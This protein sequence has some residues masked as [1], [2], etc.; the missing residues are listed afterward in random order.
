MP[1]HPPRGAPVPHLPS[2][3]E[4]LRSALALVLFLLPALAPAARGQVEITP[5]VGSFYALTSVS[6]QQDV[7]LPDFAGAPPGSIV[8]EQEDAPVLGARV[9]FPLTGTI[10][11]EGELGFAFSYG[12]LAELPRANPDA[13]LTARS[14]GH[15]YLASARAVFRP[16]RQN[17]YGLAGLGLVG[18]GGKFW[19]TADPGTKVAG[20]LGFGVRAAVSPAFSLNFSAEAYLYSFGYE[21]QGVSTGSKFQQDI[22]VA[23]GIPIGAR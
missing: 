10:R 14:K 19:E 1:G 6:E 13:G 2:S 8:R 12:R 15:M 5:F 20:V 23:I 4:S 7:P 3:L 22:I 17:F 11:A 21:S 18:R 9:S 16:R